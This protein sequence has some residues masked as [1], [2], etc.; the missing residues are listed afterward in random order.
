MG[1]PVT[2]DE[3]ALGAL[4][5]A[6]A[7]IALASLLGLAELAIR[8]FEAPRGPE[9][10]RSALGSRRSDGPV[11]YRAELSFKS[12]RAPGAASSGQI[13]QTSEGPTTVVPGTALPPVRR[14]IR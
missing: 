12:P 7:M 8:W 13:L 11:E 4:W 10:S 9:R 3:V 5:I 1:G 6:V 14:A 2:V